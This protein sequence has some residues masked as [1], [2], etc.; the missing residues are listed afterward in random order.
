M[1]ESDEWSQIVHQP[2]D[3]ADRLADG[4]LLLTHQQIADEDALVGQWEMDTVW[5]LD[6]SRSGNWSG[7]HQHT[8]GCA[9]Q[10][11]NK[12]TDILLNKGCLLLLERW[13]IF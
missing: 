9:E 4:N 12:K 13:T 10:E 7:T 2:T 1:I 3:I 6:T 11:A 8:D 5:P